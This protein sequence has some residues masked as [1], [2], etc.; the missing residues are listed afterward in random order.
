LQGN[1]WDRNGGV[2]SP[3]EPFRKGEALPGRDSFLMDEVKELA[4]LH[5][6]LS[7][8]VLES[9]KGSFPH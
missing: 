2:G 4:G 6:G 8:S 9:L 1:Y 5:S 3:A 7:S